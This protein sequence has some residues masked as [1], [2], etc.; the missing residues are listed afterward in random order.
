MVR[1]KHFEQ[2]Q[3]LIATSVDDHACTVTLQSMI[4][5][6]DLMCVSVE[7]QMMIEV[8]LQAADLFSSLFAWAASWGW[9]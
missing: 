6:I 8:T 5:L 7:Q 1:E 3:Q 2:L 4:A 9:E